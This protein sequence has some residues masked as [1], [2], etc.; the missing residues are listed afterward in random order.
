MEGVGVL[1]GVGGCL[2]DIWRVMEVGF[3]IGWGGCVYVKGLYLL[4]FIGGDVIVI[5][6]FDCFGMSLFWFVVEEVF[7]I[8]VLLGFELFMYDVKIG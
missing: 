2:I 3:D 7:L 5:G 4:I 8:G 1:F 6:I